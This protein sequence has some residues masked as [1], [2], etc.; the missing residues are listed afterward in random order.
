MLETEFAD[1][2]KRLNAKILVGENEHILQ[3]KNEMEEYFKGVRRDFS[4]P[5]DL[6]GTEFQK[7]VWKKLSNIPYGETTTYAKQ[8]RGLGKSKAIRAVGSANGANKIAIVIPC[9]RVIGSDG[10]LTGYGG[11]LHRKKWL[12][13]FENENN[14][15]FETASTSK[16]E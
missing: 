6:V 7:L 13:D 5:L 10:K 16:M 2:Q 9:H 4:V 12:L 3:L 15:S 8:A 11:G 1:L 14:L